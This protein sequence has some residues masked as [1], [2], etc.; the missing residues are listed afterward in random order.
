TISGKIAEFLLYAAER[1]PRQ[2]LT[3]EELGQVIM[4]LKTK[5]TATSQA[6]KTARG[7][8]SNARLI[9]R[10]QGADLL[11]LRGVGGRA[12]V[13][14][15][16]LAQTAMVR[17]LKSYK[18]AATRVQQ[19]IE[20]IDADTFKLAIKDAPNKDNLEALYDLFRDELKP[21]A[22]HIKGQQATLQKTLALPPPKE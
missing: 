14:T 7:A 3:Y 22:E 19:T 16:D 2:F 18:T 20:M 17:D 21:L 13:D 1:W 8:I 4:G 15:D 6:V 9:L 5:P 11:T 12:V 10:R